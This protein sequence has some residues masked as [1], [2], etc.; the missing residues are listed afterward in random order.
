MFG[1]RSPSLQVA[2]R[3]LSLNRGC[4]IVRRV[5]GIVST[6]QTLFSRLH[7]SMRLRIARQ[8]C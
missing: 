5:F 8:R 2:L 6:N 4:A 7:L 3:V 1:M